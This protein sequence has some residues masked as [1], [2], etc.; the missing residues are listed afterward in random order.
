MGRSKARVRSKNCK[1]LR[2]TG[3]QITVARTETLTPVRRRNTGWFF[4]AISGPV[5]PLWLYERRRQPCSIYSEA[6]PPF[7][8]R[9][10][11]LAGLS[12]V[13]Y[14]AD[15]KIDGLSIALLYEDG[16][17]VKE[18]TRGDGRIREVVTANVRTIKSIPL[19]L[20]PLKNSA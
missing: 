16:L 5:S 20:R 19:R 10:Q 12:A 14:V 13:D 11:Q 1:V 2:V 6:N 17:L 15:L 4:L 18:V 8:L 9:L 3:T 7:W